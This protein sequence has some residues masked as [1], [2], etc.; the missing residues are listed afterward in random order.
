M[1]LFLLLLVPE[2]LINM[3]PGDHSK[4]M[5]YDDVE[6]SFQFLEQPIRVD[7]IQGRIWPT[8]K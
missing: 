5:I 8:Y 3:A 6:N 1:S 4:F 7:A 2:R